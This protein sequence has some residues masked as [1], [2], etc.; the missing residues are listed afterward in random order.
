MHGINRLELLYILCVCFG[1]QSYALF[2]SISCAEG[3]LQWRQGS[4]WQLMALYWSS[5]VLR[6]LGLPILSTLSST[7][8]QTKWRCRPA[9]S[10][11]IL[12]VCS[13]AT[14]RLICNLASQRNW[15]SWNSRTLWT[16]SQSIMIPSHLWLSRGTYVHIISTQKSAVV[17]SQSQHM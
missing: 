16:L 1:D 17:E 9:E 15:Q 3:I 11:T 10:D 7:W 13:P 5:L 12:S 14:Y 2:K 6:R 4:K 8:Q